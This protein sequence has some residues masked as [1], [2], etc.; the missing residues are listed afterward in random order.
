MTEALSEDS[1]RIKNALTLPALKD[2]E[3]VRNIFDIGPSLFASLDIDELIRSRLL[4]QT[5]RKRIVNKEDVDKSDVNKEHKRKDT[6]TAPATPSERQKL[7]QRLN[8]IVKE[9]QDRGVGTGKERDAR[10]KKSAVGGGSA[11]ND[12][13]TGNSANAAVT[14]TASAARVRG[15]LEIRILLY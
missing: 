8:Q 6:D 9:Q 10:W 1:D 4:H 14:A 7:L 15:I 11:A 12:E 5:K 13:L 3:A 2:A